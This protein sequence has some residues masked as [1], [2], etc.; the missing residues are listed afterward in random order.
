MKMYEEIKT[1]QKVEKI[2]RHIHLSCN[3]K[4]HR[5]KENLSSFTHFLLFS[6]LEM[7]REV[8]TLDFDPFFSV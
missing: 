2:F 6:N 3:V 7:G 5:E 8:D 1:M 4:R